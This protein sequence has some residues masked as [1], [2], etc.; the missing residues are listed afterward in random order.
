MP[1]APSNAGESRSRAAPPPP[2]RCGRDRIL[3]ASGNQAGSESRRPEDLCVGG[4]EAFGA[5][6][7]ALHA[8]TC[9]FPIV[10]RASPEP[11]P[12]V[13][14]RHLATAWQ[15]IAAAGS[16]IR[17]DPLASRPLHPTYSLRCALLF[18]RCAH[19][20]LP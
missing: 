4:Y 3:D 5:N 7:R 20:S 10:S 1:S 12:G 15:N 11:S 17:H 18:N 14:Q 9:C 19:I 6:F 13:E 16:I 8:M 2:D